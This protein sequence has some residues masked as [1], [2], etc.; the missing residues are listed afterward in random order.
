MV[1]YNQ[2]RCMHMS[3]SYAGTGS[4]T[5]VGEAP[6]DPLTDVMIAILMDETYAIDIDAHQVY[7]D[8][9]A[10]SF[11]NIGGGVTNYSGRGTALASK[12]VTM[13]Q[14]NDRAEFD[15]ANTTYST[16]GNGTNDTFDQVVIARE[17]DST[18]TDGNTLLIAHT[19]VPATLTN[20]G[21]ITLV[22][23]SE[24]ILQITT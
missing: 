11:E 17:Q 3:G 4:G 13:D 24:G 22:W 15:A 7:S 23:N 10:T 12:T 6:Y 2:G 8:I 21:N 16:L 1:F 5:A 14:A 19:A 20:G 18:P 9:S